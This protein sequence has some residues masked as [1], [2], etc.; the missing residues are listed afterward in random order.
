MFEKM[1]RC[2][3][4]A[5]EFVL[6]LQEG[7]AGPSD[8]NKITFWDKECFVGN[9]GG[10]TTITW[11]GDR[12]FTYSRGQGWSDQQ[13]SYLSTRGAAR[14]VWESR[15]GINRALR[16]FLEAKLYLPRRLSYPDLLDAFDKAYPP[17]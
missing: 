3:Q 14:Y 15:K 8:G 2:K 7:T 9:W 5:K 12:F 4:D 16:S 11:D 1:I 6:A 10:S 17:Q 13:P